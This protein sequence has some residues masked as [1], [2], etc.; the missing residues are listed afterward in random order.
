MEAITGSGY[1]QTHTLLLAA[2]TGDALRCGRPRMSVSRY[3]GGG[4]ED[5]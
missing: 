2:L 4:S 3:Y 1:T 5:D